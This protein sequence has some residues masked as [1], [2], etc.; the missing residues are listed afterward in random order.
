MSWL[1]FRVEGPMSA[2][3]ESLCCI[4]ALH[5]LVLLACTCAAQLPLQVQGSQGVVEKSVRYSAGF[6]SLLICH[7]LKEGYFFGNLWRFDK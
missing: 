2:L 7:A 5:P 6:S 4:A 1:V 3:G